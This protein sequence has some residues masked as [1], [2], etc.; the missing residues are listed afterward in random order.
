MDY[1]NFLT[2][3]AVGGSLVSAWAVLKYALLGT[4]R[5]NSD[6]ARRFLD[7][8]KRDSTWTWELGTELTVDPKYPLVHETL[9]VLQGMP[10]F[11]SKVERLLTAGWQGK[12][13]MCTVTFLRWHRTRMLQY[14]TREITLSAIT[15]SALSPG[16]VDRLGELEPGGVK[17]FFLNEGSYEDIEADVAQVALGGLKR[18]SMLLYGPPGNGKTNF[19]R[20]LARKYSLPIYVIYFSP[21]Y[22]NLDIARMFSEVPR[23]CIIL[24][25]DFDNYFDGR[26]C[27]MKN[28][29]VKFT[30]DSIINALDGV[31][32]DYRGVVFAMTANNIDRIDPSLKCRPSRFKFVREFG[33][34][35]RKLR[36]RILGSVER[37]EETEGLSLDAVFNSR[38]KA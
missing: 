15:V 34:P 18:T 26:T 28:D 13:E 36:E 24:F 32:N 7:R 35:D 12:E 19:I 37:A 27:T 20:Q 1:S 33:N 10:I 21:D 6:S 30:F 2:I 4:Y 14:L 9:A 17:E 38:E 5:L 8:I 23:R 16:C 25:E 11:F 3:A 29:Q 22:N 31:H